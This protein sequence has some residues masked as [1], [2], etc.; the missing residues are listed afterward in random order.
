MRSRGQG[1]KN[2]DK[3]TQSIILTQI[4]NQPGISTSDLWGILHSKKEKLRRMKTKNM[5]Y[6]HL[7]T[8]RKKGYIESTRHHRRDEQRHTLK[9]G[10]EKFVD[11][12]NFLDDPEYRTGLANTNYYKDY[13]NIDAFLEKYAVYRFKK[14]ITQLNRYLSIPAPGKFLEDREKF[15]DIFHVTQGDQERFVKEYTSLAKQMETH[16]V[17]DLLP[18]IKDRIKDNTPPGWIIEPRGHLIF[19]ALHMTNER[20]T[21]SIQNMLRDSPIVMSFLLNSNYYDPI[22]I[23]NLLAR[24]TCLYSINEKALREAMEHSEIDEEPYFEI[25]ELIDRYKIPEEKNETPMFQ[26]LKGLAICTKVTSL[27]GKTKKRSKKQ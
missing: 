23:Q 7:R 18:A 22:L 11:L 13:T 9:P 1:G 17:D 3:I 16:H 24:I 15:F 20:E 19:L 10:F 27:T 8:L 2:P 12:Y 5:L 25:E 6:I 4:A 14:N 26:V 21:P